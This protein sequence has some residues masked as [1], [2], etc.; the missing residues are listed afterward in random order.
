MTR[1]SLAHVAIAAVAIPL[2]LFLL[3]LAWKPRSEERDVLTGYIQADTLYLSSPVAGPVAALEERRGQ[4]V[5][6]GDVLFVMDRKAVDS[7]KAQAQA[8]LA[9]AQAQGAQQQATLS[10]AVAKA[11][12]AE[13]QR[14]NAALDLARYRGARAQAAGSVSDQQ[15]DAARLSL[16]DAEASLK[17]ANQEVAGDRSAIAAAQAKAAEQNA[18]VTETD[19][20]LSQLQGVAPAPG[21]IQETLY[22]AGEWAPANKPIIALIPDAKV[23]VRFYVPETNLGRYSIGRTVHFHCD[24]CQGDL[25]AR[26][27]YVSASPEYTPPVIYSLK[28]RAKLVFMIEAEPARPASLSPGQPVDVDPLK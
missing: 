19:V 27:S 14:R 16:A 23:K 24:G 4:R 10:G 5:A 8:R 12:A 9:Q 15:I 6:A 20:K 11:T 2:V 28:M 18:G 3:W 17:A 25:T 26:I 7:Q 22:E 13:T 1:P 21:R